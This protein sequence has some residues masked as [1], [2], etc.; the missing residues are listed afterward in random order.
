M[1]DDKL[2]VRAKLGY[3]VGDLGPGLMFSAV[4]FYFLYFLTDIVR[5]VPQL[6]GLAV[7]AGKIYDAVDDPV[8]GY[9]SDRTRTRL[10]RRRPFMLA[11]AVPFGLAFALIWLSPALSQAG[12]FWY[13][14]GTFILLSTALA[15]F[16][17][18]YASLTADLTRDYDER[19][20]LT[21][22]RMLFSIVGTLFAG[23]ATMMIVGLRPTEKEGF[24]F[25]GL[26]F[27]AVIALSA[28]ISV[29]GTRERAAAEDEGTNLPFVR[30]VKVALANRPF[31]AALA[32]YFLS[33]CAMTIV[34]ALLIYY[35]KYVAGLGGQSSLV[36]GLLLLVAVGALPLW[37]RLSAKMGKA[38]AFAL[39]LGI[40]ALAMLVF[41]VLP[42]GA[43]WAVY[44]LV[45]VAGVGTAT[46]YVFPWA[47][48]PDVVEYDQLTTGQRR[49][50][51]FYGL[52]L[53][54]QKIAAA[55][56]VMLSGALLGWS[57]YVAGAEQTA[58][59]IVGLRL[60]IGPLPVVLIL[61]A[62]AFLLR[63]PINRS[64]HEAVVRRIAAGEGSLGADPT[65]GGVGTAGASG[66]G[67]GAG[68][69]GGGVGAGAS[70]G[71]DL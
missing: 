57:G 51:T 26:V 33:Q 56:G 9:L 23:A 55:T 18:P 44:A 13:A 10:G 70:G 59:A 54:T 31:R 68:A 34:S 37:V 52:W 3:G 21:S 47:M 42:A 53:L 12:R 30:G 39:G 24:A 4:N 58:R 63:Y 41:S 66:G 50:G 27:G 38:R 49:A 29:L 46:H 19:T 48:V 2:P 35:L 40:Q 22:F 15:V 17:V 25:M 71:V 5:L 65:G 45:L 36:F 64:A 43:T 16:N 7:M 6:A 11:A 32:I 61:A 28:L 69:N 67:V 20:S 60:G 8:V 1:S 62:G 14:V